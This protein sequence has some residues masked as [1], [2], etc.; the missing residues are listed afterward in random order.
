MFCKA[1]K[2]FNLDKEKIDCEV[3]TRSFVFGK[4]SKPKMLCFYF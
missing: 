3:L 1:K 4:V 2:M